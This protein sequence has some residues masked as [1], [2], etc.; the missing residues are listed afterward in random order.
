MYMLQV[1]VLYSNFYGMPKCCWGGQLSVLHRW[2]E[3]YCNK[4]TKKKKM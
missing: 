4:K 3:N 2:S 1:C